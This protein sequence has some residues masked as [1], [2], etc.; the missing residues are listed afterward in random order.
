MNEMENTDNQNVEGLESF[1]REVELPT[2]PVR[3]SECE[4]IVDVDLFINSHHEVLKENNGTWRF[5][6]CFDRM[7]KLKQILTKSLK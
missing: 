4:V 3:I 2:G 6:A 5:E 7:N 1:F